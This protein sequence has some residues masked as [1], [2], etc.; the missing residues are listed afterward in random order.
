MIRTPFMV[1]PLVLAIAAC[2][3]PAPEP[4]ASDAATTAAAATPAATPAPAVTTSGAATPAAAVAAAP[5]AFGQCKV[6]HSVEKGK[7]G[8]G[9]SLAGVYG[10]KAAEIADYKF[11]PAMQKSGLTWDDAT[12]DRYLAAPMKVVPGTKMSFAGLADP[13]KRA[14]IIAYMKTI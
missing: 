7:H 13:A 10:T 12:L 8:V 6:C 14:E 11:S 3:Q 4:A 5:A 1:A 2:G 9:P